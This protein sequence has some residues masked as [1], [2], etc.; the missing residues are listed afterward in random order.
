MKSFRFILIAALLFVTACAPVFREEIMKNSTLNPSLPELNSKPAD[1]DGRMYILG[2]RI[3]NTRSTEDGIVIEAMS[4]L[5]DSRGHIDY[6]D[7]YRGRFMAIMPKGKGM[8][9]PLIFSSG[10][11]VTIAGIYKGIRTGMIDKLEY[12]YSY[13][14]I[15]G[16]RLW[17]RAA[18]YSGPVYYAP[19]PS[20]YYWY[21]PGYYH[22]YRHW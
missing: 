9:D 3:L 8:L 1:F 11:D 18:Y 17:E 13:F 6:S 21:G 4:L 10:K 19:Y 2:G 14:E 16:I 12:S 7:R 15:V 20:Y 22:H 5:V